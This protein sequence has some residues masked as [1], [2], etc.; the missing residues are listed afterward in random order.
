MVQYELGFPNRWIALP[1]AAT[2]GRMQD[3]KAV[4][5]SP[6]DGTVLKYTLS[7]TQSPFALVMAEDQKT[8]QDVPIVRTDTSTILSFTKLLEEAGELTINGQTC[9]VHLVKTELSLVLWD[10]LP[11][12]A[13]AFPSP[14]H[15]TVKI[16]SV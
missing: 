7:Q 5:G 10:T 8:L 3:A 16:W 15:L 2:E 13:V 4:I 6:E 14:S 9:W 11:I 12:H 1:V